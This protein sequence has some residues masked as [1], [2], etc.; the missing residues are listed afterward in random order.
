VIDITENAR[1][2]MVFG[3]LFAAHLA[4]WT[5]GWTGGSLPSHL[6]WLDLLVAALCLLVAR[7]WHRPWLLLSLSPVFVHL[8]GQRGWISL[9]DT[10]LEWGAASISAGFAMLFGSLLGSWKIVR[11]AH[12]T[13]VTQT[14]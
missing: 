7:R 3:A 8:A 10:A 5:T 1:P 6:L 12:K 11:R 14:G 13:S 4:A 9:P 2:R